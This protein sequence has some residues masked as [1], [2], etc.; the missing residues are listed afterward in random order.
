VVT[1]IDDGHGMPNGAH[2]GVG[3]TSMRERV[4][5]LGGTLRLLTN[6]AG[7][8]TVVASLPLSRRNPT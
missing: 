7:G 4:E 3:L 8:T 1:V 2:A 6:D 5:E